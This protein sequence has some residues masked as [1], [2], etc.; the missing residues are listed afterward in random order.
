MAAHFEIETTRINVGKTGGYFDVRGLNTED[1]TFLTVH[2]LE[3]IKHAVADYGERS[4]AGISHDALTDLIMSIAKDF[5]MMVVEIISRC[6]ESTSAED[7]AKFRQLSFPKQIE[8][9]RAISI[10][11]TEDGGIDLKKVLGVVASL[12]EVNGVKRG[13]LMTS[14]MT[15]IETFGS[16]SPTS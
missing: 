3:D 7:V 1:V 8:A 13:P 15:T 14:L 10:L 2:Y 12:L 9:L 11:T 16:Q 6:A 5:P 4:A